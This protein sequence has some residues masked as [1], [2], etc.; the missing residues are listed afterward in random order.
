MSVGLDAV[1]PPERVLHSDRYVAMEA[2]FDAAGPHGKRMMCNTAALQVNI[3]LGPEP[4]AHRWRLANALGPTLIA[5]FA[6]SPFGEKA[7]AGRPIGWVA[8][9]IATWWGIDPSRTAP[10]LMT[11]DPVSA[12][13]RYALDAKVLLIH[14]EAGAVPQVR[15]A[16]TFGRW[17]ASGHEL[18]WPT[19]DDMAYHLTTLFPPVRPRGWLELRMLDALDDE[20]WPVAVAVLV[21]LLTEPDAA[22]DVEA[23]TAATAPLWLEAAHH[24]LAHPDLAAS[25]DVC[26]ALA[27]EA[28]PRL[29]VDGELVDAVAAYRERY[30]ATRRCPADDLLYEYEQS[31][32]MLPGGTLV[33]PT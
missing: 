1:R 18:G 22:G 23:A 26:F 2:V 29:S 31:G 11:G 20:V 16:P 27:L 13:L 21:A 32:S 3:D 24:G 17:M 25:A 12:W 5:C 30:V 10:P 9:R 14:T 19:E 6:N 8:N 4:V 7:G 15:D 28:L 33:V